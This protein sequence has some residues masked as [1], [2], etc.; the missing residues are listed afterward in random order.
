MAGSCCCE[1]PS[2]S[3]VLC[4]NSLAPERVEL[5]GEV[6]VLSSVEMSDPFVVDGGG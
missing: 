1:D 3:V 6:G 5:V 4:F 2:R